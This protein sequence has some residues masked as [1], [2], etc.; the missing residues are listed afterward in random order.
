V[1]NG[2]IPDKG[3]LYGKY[4]ESRDWREN[5]HKQLAH[6]SL[7]IGVDE[8]M[9]VDNS[10]QSFGMTWKEMLVIAAT[11]IGGFVAYVYSTKEPPPVNW[12]P[13][14]PQQAAS[15]LKDSEY[16]VLFYDANMNPIQVQP[17]Q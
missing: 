7:D 3:Y 14:T 11:V 15:P 5:L 16:Q 9:R 8:E 12:P 17:V 2:E 10:R 6:K 13:L 1:A 4:Q